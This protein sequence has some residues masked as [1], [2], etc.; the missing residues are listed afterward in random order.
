MRQQLGTVERRARQAEHTVE[1]ERK[2][3]EELGAQLKAA[4][5]RVA[6]LEKLE[7]TVEEGGATSRLDSSGATTPPYLDM[8]G[9]ELASAGTN[10]GRQ[11]GISVEALSKSLDMMR[12]KYEAVKDKYYR[13]AI[14][15]S[16]LQDYF[17]HLQSKIKEAEEMEERMAERKEKNASGVRR[18]R[19]SSDLG[20][21]IAAFSPKREEKPAK[22]RI[23]PA[24]RAKKAETAVED[25]EEEE[26][27][28]VVRE[29][30]KRSKPSQRPA[31]ASTAQRRNMVQ[32]RERPSTASRVSHR[33][34][35]RTYT[36]TTSGHYMES[37]SASRKKVRRVIRS[38]SEER[39][40]P[41]AAEKRSFAF[42]VVPEA[43]SNVGGKMGRSIESASLTSPWPVEQAKSKKEGGNKKKK[44]GDDRQQ[45]QQGRPR[46]EEVK[47]LSKG[48]LVSA[49][50]SR[51]GKAQPQAEKDV[52]RQQ[53]NKRE[54]V[55]S[56]YNEGE[57]VEEILGSTKRPLADAYSTS[58]SDLPPLD[59][60]PGA[61]TSKR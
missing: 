14:R 45:Q 19:A 61:S 16:Q 59:L 7:R 33:T 5:S 27:V 31:S 21:E 8:R 35:T 57:S 25:E 30:V 32:T 29:D 55:N 22:K 6:V 47:K 41:R 28:V 17:F 43:H 49:S 11:E 44:E 50:P 60:P 40:R 46:K 53:Q 39:R 3:K 20:K 13:Q 18:E 26:E 23:S 51:K 24:K 42:E 4:L 54:A 9:E 37:T 15:H 1:S 48:I 12:Q 10:G 58:F 2:E 56:S 52:E 34:Q 38:N 36:R